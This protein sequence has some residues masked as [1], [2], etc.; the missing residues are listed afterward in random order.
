MAENRKRNSGILLH[1]SSLPS[2]Y[3]IGDMG[4]A[5]YSFVDFLVK[6][7]QH[8]WQILPLTAIDGAFGYSPYSSVSAFAGNALFISPDSLK[9][10]GFL[11]DEDLAGVPEFGDDRIEYVRVSDYKNFVLHTAYKRFC[12]KKCPADYTVFCE[13]HKKW[14]DDYA[15][16]VS[17]K[18]EDPARSW[19]DWNPQLRDR[20]TIALD[21][22]TARLKDEVRYV[23]FVQYCFF[24][25]W[26][27][28]KAYANKNAIQIVGD[29]PIYVTYDGVDVWANSG[30]F[31]LTED[32]KMQCVAGVPPDYFSK[33]GQLWGNPIYNW[34]V[35]QEN[36]FLWWRSRMR[37]IFDLYDIVRLDHFRGFV[38]YWEVP[39]DHDTAMEGKWVDA[40]AY[41]YFSLLMDEFS[42]DKI[43][44]E[45]LG[46]ITDDV[47]AI[48]KEFGFGGMKVLLFAFEDN[49]AE[50]PYIPHNYTRDVVVYTGTHDN[51]TI[52]G[53]F[54][55]D[56]TDVNKKQL[57]KYLGHAVD[58]RDVHND[59]IRLALGSV[60]DTVIIPMQD[61]LGLGVEA[62]M[63]V[64]ATS[65]G[66]WAW[67]MPALDAVA[68]SCA[69]FISMVAL[70]GRA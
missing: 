39:A 67:R 51:N 27:A 22:A 28:L 26:Y 18:K 70:Y 49:I 46:V 35:M 14:L 66:N 59:V 17:L 7:K 30:L 69:Q 48:M 2:Q 53:W 38:G 40:P 33:T 5:A 50:H 23:K 1:I 19:S 56:A 55:H 42:K 44:A 29:I 54:E 62:R 9:A 57:E 20:D 16:F 43:I 13:H 41:E 32:K 6:A 12:A 15:L 4:P 34:D 24:K 10:D 31:K 36:D 52:R 65:E 45:D 58:V 37:F 11:S 47:R 21:V 3:G 8:I 60:A 61:I 25:Q 68:S 64:P 63:N